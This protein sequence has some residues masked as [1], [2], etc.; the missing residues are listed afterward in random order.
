MA[1]KEVW[2]KGDAYEQY[3]GRWSRLV[4]RDFLDWLDPAA[5]Q[6]W[7][8]I[9]CGT[10]ALSAAIIERCS[11]TLITGIDP[12]AGFLATARARIADPRARFEQ[13]DAQALPLEGGA[14]DV[15]VSGLVLNF[16]GNPGAMLGEMRRVLRPGGTVALYVWDYA[17]KMQL[18]RYFWD[19]AADLDPSA[20]ELDEGVRFPICRPEALTRMLR[21]A[22]LEAVATKPIDMPT[23]FRDFEEYWSPF[24]GG[25][26]AAPAYCMSL[27]DERRAAL[28]NR[29]QTA[30]PIEA[31]GR[32][33]LIARAF[34]V[35]GTVPVP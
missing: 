21:D 11:P 29:L 18:M 10:G 28:R 30:L 7:L 23:V 15:A 34:A 13:G 16:V 8:D 33:D 1:G 31:N 24:L 32:I 25:Q 35:R 26:G 12:S 14:F 5:G 27:S 17:E 4:A 6:C 2:E 22:G 19:A 3:L 20:R 9:G